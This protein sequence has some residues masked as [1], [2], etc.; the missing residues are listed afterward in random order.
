M[1]LLIQP[2]KDLEFYPT[3]RELAK[4]MVDKL[5]NVKS[6]LE[7]SAGMGMLANVFLS[8]SVEVDV[9][10]IDS[11]LR[12]YLEENGFNVVGKDFLSFE[13]TKK[14]DAIVMNPPYSIAEKHI[15]K[16]ISILEKTG[17]GTILTQASQNLMKVWEE[18]K[19]LHNKLAEL[20]FS[21]KQ[22]G[23][24]YENSEYRKTSVPVILLEIEVEGNKNA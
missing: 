19:D 12:N 7:P 11:K 8:N 5:P 6:I 20:N 23:R 14:Y 13:T 2:E 16:A 3:T 1:K 18:T 22:L 4:L 21:V 10:E 17:G 24:P 15:L 9:C